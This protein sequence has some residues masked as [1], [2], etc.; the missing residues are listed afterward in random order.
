M[1]IAPV[2]SATDNPIFYHEVDTGAAGALW[3]GVINNTLGNRSDCEAC[4]PGNLPCTGRD[5]FSP[6]TM[7]VTVVKG[8]GWW[9]DSLF[10]PWALFPKEF[11]APWPVWRV[12]FYRYDYPNGA[13]EPYELSGWSPTHN[14]SFHVPARFGTMLL[15]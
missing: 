2:Y 10:L 15:I 14:P 11:A 8:T 5:N 9:A 7:S 6:L 12:N 13:S 4:V 3:A 1:F